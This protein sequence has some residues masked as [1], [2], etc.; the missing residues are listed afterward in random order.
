MCT[1]VL[2]FAMVDGGESVLEYVPTILGWAFLLL[3]PSIITAII[4]IL[5]GYTKPSYGLEKEDIPSDTYR[6]AD[7]R[8]DK[9]E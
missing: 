1:V 3:A 5:R 8:L 7:M 6:Y 9:N 4:F 2:Y